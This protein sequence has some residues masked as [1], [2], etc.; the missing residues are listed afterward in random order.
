MLPPPQEAGRSL[1]APDRDDLIN[2]TQAAA[3]LETHIGKVRKLARSGVLGQVFK[4]PMDCRVRL[5]SRKRVVAFK[6]S[7]VEPVG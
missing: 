5:A 7:H 4:D 3:L 2:F 1:S 6:E